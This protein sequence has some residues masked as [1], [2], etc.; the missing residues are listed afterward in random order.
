MQ[1]TRLRE[2][3]Q[4]RGLKQTELAELVGLSSRSI[5]GY[6]RGEGIHPHNAR[7]IADT[8]GIEVGD[9]MS[10]DDHPK[11][12]A[13]PFQ[14][15]SFSD[16]LE[17]E[18]RTEGFRRA[19]RDLDELCDHLED[20]IDRGTMTP[21]EIETLRR[22]SS[23]FA[24]FM[25]IAM[26][27]EARVLKEQYPDEADVTPKALVGPAVARYVNLVMG[28]LDSAEAQANVIDLEETRRTLYRRA[29]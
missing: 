11:G 23:G 3:R 12:S 19:R 4:F 16:V 13:P 28:A 2:W 1:I 26:N 20:R 17:E 21:G 15:P 14:Q 29:G 9:L 27:E 18:R 24:A 5:A 8:L 6:E 22:E 7:R 10:E 25:Q